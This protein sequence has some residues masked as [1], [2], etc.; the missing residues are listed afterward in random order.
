MERRGPQAAQAFRESIRL[1]GEASRGRPADEAAVDP[2]AWRLLAQV[3]LEAGRAEVAQLALEDLASRASLEGAA[4]LRDLAVQLGDGRDEGR[5]EACLRLALAHDRHDPETWRRLAQLL[6]R[7]RRPEEARRA[8]EA[9]LREAPDDAEA[10]ISAGRLA[11]RAGERDA[12]RAWFG[13]AVQVARDEGAARAAV[14]FAWLDVRRP[15]DAREVVEAGLRTAPGDGRLRYAEG[16][17]LAEQRRWDAAAAAYAAVEGEDE[18][19]V[20][21]ARAGQVLALAQGGRAT[22][23]LAVVDAELRR[24]PGHPRLVRIRAVALERAGRAPEALEMLRTASAAQP[25]DEDLRFA[26]AMAEDRAGHRDAAVR[27]A[28]GLLAENPRHA[29]ALN[30][31]AY[32]WATGGE[33]LEEAERLAAR[34]LDQQPE[35]PAYLD[36]MGWILYQRGD[37]ARAIGLLERAEALGGAEPT[38]LEHLGDAYR[39]ARRSADAALAYE[40]ALAVL[41]EGA[42]PETPDQRAHI[43]RKLGEI[44]SSGLRP[45]RR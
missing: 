16:T 7:R 15:G 5:A 10:L 35:N 31:L 25:R 36:S 3:E 42:E 20:V 40:R 44:R 37:A 4:A 18:E 45:A 27:V 8:W 30:Y 24:R 12:A 22:D 21:A 13:Q 29:D 1:Q 9:M 41:D 34:A 6:E 32:T 39:R 23:G 43:E 14:A 38:I 33:R 26:L 17:V 28:E 11:L 2:D 19:L